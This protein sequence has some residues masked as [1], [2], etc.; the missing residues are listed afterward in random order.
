MRAGHPFWK[1]RRLTTDRRYAAGVAH[2]WSR[3]IFLDFLP[4]SLIIE[5]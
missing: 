1:C 2:P 5:A 4:I 3:T